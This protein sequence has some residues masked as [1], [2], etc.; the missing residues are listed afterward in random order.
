MS[1]LVLVQVHRIF[2]D[3]ET[4]LNRPTSPGHLHE[5]LEIRADWAENH[6]ICK[7]LGLLDAAPEYCLLTPTLLLPFFKKPVSSTT[8][9]NCSSPRYSTLDS[10]QSVQGVY[11]THAPKTGQLTR[12][13][14]GHA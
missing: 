11:T 3:L 6:V 13:A 2:G 10:D 4:L 9:T 12:S 5:F 1:Y 8:S 14:T 7:F